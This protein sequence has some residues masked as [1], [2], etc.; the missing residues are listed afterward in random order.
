MLEL[1]QRS[2]GELVTLQPAPLRRRVPTG[3]APLVVAVDQGLATTRVRASR[4]EGFRREEEYSTPDTYPGVLHAL[5]GAKKRLLGQRTYPDVVG[6]SVA[7]DVSMVERKPQ[8]V[9]AGDLQQSVDE[10][11]ALG[12]A[13]AVGLLNPEA[14][15]VLNQA[16]AGAYAEMTDRPDRIRDEAF[17]TRDGHPDGAVYTPEGRIFPDKPEHD[18]SGDIVY[19]MQLIL[20]RHGRIPLYVARVA[21]AAPPAFDEAG[22]DTLHEAAQGVHGSARAPEIVLARFGERGELNPLVGAERAAERLVK[23]HEWPHIDYR[24]IPKPKTG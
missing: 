3:G 16:T 22:I 2:Q 24:G 15:V 19:G 17:F 11:F 9:L 5:I 7:G 14:L 8:V 13:S 18:E 6:L 20:Q 10:S 23:N 12:V 21:L 1:A 4:G